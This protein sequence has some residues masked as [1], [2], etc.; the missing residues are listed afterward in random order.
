MNKNNKKLSIPEVLPPIPPPLQV[1]EP[2][3]PLTAEDVV[4]GINETMGLPTALPPPQPVDAE[5]HRRRVQL[6]EQQTDYKMENTAQLLSEA[7]QGYMPAKT[8]KLIKRRAMRRAEEDIP[9]A[10]YVERMESLGP[11]QGESYLSFKRRLASTIAARELFLATAQEVGGSLP[12]ICARVGISRSN[13]ANHLRQ[14]GL[15]AEDLLRFNK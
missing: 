12:E 2:Q 4:D 15:R 11:R 1:T 5:H 14:A 8:S 6:A 9:S 13:I 10:D 7:K 3:P